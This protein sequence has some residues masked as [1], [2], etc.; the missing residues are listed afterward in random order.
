MPQVWLKV[1]AQKNKIEIFNL[2]ITRKDFKN[3]NEQKQKG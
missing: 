1:V 2:P 3:Q